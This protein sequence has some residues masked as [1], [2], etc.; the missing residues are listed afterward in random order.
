MEKIKKTIQTSESFSPE[1]IKGLKTVGKM[2]GFLETREME[3]WAKPG[4]IE[5]LKLCREISRLFNQKRKQIVQK[6]RNEMFRVLELD[7]G[8]AN[9][10]SLT[11]GFKKAIEKVEGISKENTEEMAGAITRIETLQKNIEILSSPGK[12]PYKELVNIVKDLEQKRLTLTQEINV[13][14][15]NVK[16]KKD[17][18][19][20]SAVIR[21]LKSSLAAITGTLSNRQG[22]HTKL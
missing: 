13:L 10:K 5:L 17:N 14:E 12:K 1:F 3:G 18:R 16:K 4:D 22:C 2:T 7:P 6:A 8:S 21:F 9:T 11:A 15:N 20:I 19:I